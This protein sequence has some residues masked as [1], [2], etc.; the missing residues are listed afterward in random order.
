M[1]SVKQAKLAQGIR[2]E[3][4]NIIDSKK[5]DL[6]FEGGMLHVKS[7]ASDSKYGPF[8]VF[9][10]NI[11]WLEIEEQEAAAEIKPKAKK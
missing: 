1:I 3:V 6:R 2:G 9:P 10:A 11:A 8:I 7:R 4:S 5:Y